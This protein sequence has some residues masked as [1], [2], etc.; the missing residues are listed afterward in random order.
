MHF[1]L[2]TFVSN[3]FPVEQIRVQCVSNWTCP[4]SQLDTFL[5]QLGTNV[6]LISNWI[7]RVSNHFQSFPVG[8]LIGYIGLFLIGYQTHPG[9][10]KYK[11]LMLPLCWNLLSKQRPGGSSWRRQGKFRVVTRSARV[12]QRLDHD[13]NVP[14]CLRLR[15]A[16]TSHFRCD[17]S[18]LPV[19]PALAIIPVSSKVLYP[20]LDTMF[21][22]WELD[23]SKKH[24][25]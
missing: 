16:T 8:N 14:L 3:V 13:A 12:Q 25:F 9:W 11:W 17:N 4:R 19:H 24:R 20:T 18:V 6:Q 21:N 10:E 22:Y 2:V 23:M 15:F 7:F 5:Y 1:Q